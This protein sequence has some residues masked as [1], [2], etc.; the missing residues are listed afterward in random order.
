[1]L[2]RHEAAGAAILSRSGLCLGWA[3]TGRLQK[4]R[5][6]RVDS[7]DRPYGTKIAGLRRI[8]RY[9]MSRLG[10]IT[11]P[12]L[13]AVLGGATS[14]CSA[15]NSSSDR[16]TDSRTVR[17]SSLLFSDGINAT[18]PKHRERNWQSGEVPQWEV[19]R[20]FSSGR[21]RISGVRHNG[22]VTE[23]YTSTSGPKGSTERRRVVARST[24][25]LHN[26]HRHRP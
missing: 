20:T 18:I 25:G 12:M 10:Q 19:A 2:A 1:M 16:L 22:D 8:G 9:A 14:G 13:L 6:K 24:T 17:S 3:L 5:T 11:A 7:A 4:L 21:L 15:P 23:Y 26:G